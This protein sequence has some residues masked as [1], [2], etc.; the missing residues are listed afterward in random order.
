MLKPR[1]MDSFNTLSVGSTLHGYTVVRKEDLPDI[2]ATFYQLEHTGGARHIHLSRDDDNHSFT[3][4]FPTVPQ[5]SGGVA[6]ILEHIVLAGSQKYPTKD[7]F[8][9][10]I[11]R[12]LNTFMN[13]FTSSDWTAYPFSTRNRADYFNL[14]SIY[15]DATFFP[16]LTKWTFLREG[17]RLEYADPADLNSKLG[18]QGVV[19]NE[20]KGAMSSPSS[21][22]YK[23]LGKALYPD[24]TYAHN[25][26]G[27]PEAIP[28]LTWEGLRAFHRKHYHPSN[29]YFYTYGN[30][31]L[32]KSLEFIEREVLSKFSGE[33]RDVPLSPRRRQEMDTSIPDQ[34][35]FESPREVSGTFPSSETKS[36]SQVSIGWV[37]TPSFDAYRTLEMSILSDVLLG[38]AAAPL[39]MA[40]IDSGLGASLSDGTGFNPEFREAMFTAGLKDTRPE[41]ADQIEKIVLGTLEE[42]AQKGLDESAIESSLHQLELNRKEVSNAGF[43]YSLNVFFQFASTWMYGGDPLSAL[44]FNADLE[45]LGENRK[46]ENYF[47]KLIRRE[48]LDNPH[49]VKIVLTPDPLLAGQKLENEEK[50]IRELES[51]LDNDGKAKVVSE[52]LELL[53]MQDDEDDNN[54]LLPTLALSDI[55][56]DVPDV[57]VNR[58]ERDGVTLGLCA[59]PTN[60]L[61]YVDVQLETAHLSERQQD[62]MPLYTYALTKSGAGQLDYLEVARLLE[63]RTGGVGASVG[64]TPAPDSLER[65]HQHLSLSGKALVRNAAALLEL[66]RDFLA[67][68]QFDTGRLY[69]LL[70]QQRTG[71]QAGVVQNGSRYAAML[72]AAQ[73]SPLSALSESQSGLSLLERLKALVGDDES[74]TAPLIAEFEDLSRALLQGKASVLVTAERGTLDSLELDGLLEP[75]KN[76]EPRTENRKPAVLDKTAPSGRLGENGTFRASPPVRL[77]MTRT[78]RARTTDVPVSYNAQ[79]FPGVP[80]AHPDSPAL[81]ALA[82]LLTANYTL[83]ELREKG[84]AYGGSASYSPQ[85]GMFSF[86]SYR[87]PHIERTFEVFRGAL[88]FV[89]SNEV[90]T[91]ELEEALIRSGGALDP[92]TSPDTL[93]RSRFFSDLSGYSREKQQEFRKR[94]VA[95]TLA[96]VRRVASSY[97]KAENS[98][99]ALISN[100]DKVK[101]VQEK[102]A[103]EVGAI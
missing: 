14:L 38:N 94:L 97:L 99:I 25:S 20:M 78:P 96:D 26:G 68:P 52:A 1:V 11:S 98:A 27:D 92:L 42:L 9:S 49:R 56:T 31:A 67:S 100:A 2:Q 40:L 36:S 75:L 72:A 63:A 85:S 8:F 81:F 101:E 51:A 103:L 80:Y 15:L 48:L 55:R 76:R 47:G 84:G 57:L 93:G 30:M 77:P 59:Q 74:S 24:L 64:L 87:D 22:M 18:L 43:P 17:H 5:D 7:P 4:I 88:E 33:A 29:A 53:K 13:A 90:G 54:D 28:G 60:G 39:R 73:L 86:T 32:E 50:L 45:R 44:Q 71:K 91:Q 16:L 102:M 79:V 62:L 12:S 95:V 21:V 46:T 10:M 70:K 35:R 66:M 19:Y 23:L 65:A 58:L 3:V 83:R 37:T 69:Q 89:N 6:H 82:Q 41:H 34:P 61:L